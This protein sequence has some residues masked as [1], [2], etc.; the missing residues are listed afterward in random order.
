MGLFYSFW[1]PYPPRL[2]AI[3]PTIALIAP[4]VSIGRFRFR[5]HALVGVVPG[6]LR[7]LGARRDSRTAPVGLANGSF[8]VVTIRRAEL[9]KGLTSL[10]AADNLAI[11][12]A[13]EN[14]GVEFIAENGGG[15]GVH[16]RESYSTKSR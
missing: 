16:L 2:C 1:P 8:S 12:H 10:T 3:R 13:L 7:S 9:A 11:R 6:K 4:K 14:E 5:S 15:A